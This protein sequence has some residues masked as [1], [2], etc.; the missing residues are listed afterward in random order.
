MAPLRAIPKGSVVGSYTTNSVLS[1][2]LKKGLEKVGTGSDY[3]G[4]LRESTGM[5]GGQKG[6]SKTEME[7]ASSTEG[8]EQGTACWCAGQGGLP[9]EGPQHLRFSVH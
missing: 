5:W 1:L 7:I 4:Q 2:S 3:Q 6:H 9:K 8:K